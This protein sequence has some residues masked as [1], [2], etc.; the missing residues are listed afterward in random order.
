MAREKY[1]TREVTFTEVSALYLNKQLLT[2]EEKLTILVGSFDNEV[3]ILKEL[4]RVNKD[5]LLTPI[6]VMEYNTTSKLFGLK[7]NDFINL[8]IE[9]NPETRRPY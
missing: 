3:D 1:I 5:E 4:N 8:A 6:H 7:E 9:L 2:N